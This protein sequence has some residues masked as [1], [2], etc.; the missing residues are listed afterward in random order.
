MITRR[1]LQVVLSLGAAILTIGIAHSGDYKDT[2]SLLR[3]AG[4]SDETAKDRISNDRCFPFLPNHS[5][6]I[7][8]ISGSSRSYSF[9]TTA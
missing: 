9:L 2:I 5:D 1:S 6:Y 4:E 7:A 3:N 8:P